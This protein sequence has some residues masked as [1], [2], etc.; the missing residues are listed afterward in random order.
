MG[1]SFRGV[2]YDALVAASDTP[3][4]LKKFATHFCTGTNDEVVLQAASLAAKD[5]RCGSL[6]GAYNLAFSTLY[7]HSGTLAAGA[8]TISLDTLFPVNTV[9]AI[10]GAYGYAS[11]TV[12][13]SGTAVTW[14][15]G[16]VFN[17]G[18]LSGATIRINGTAYLISSVADTTHLTL[19]SSAGTQSAV[20][21]DFLA[22]TLEYRT[23]TNVSGAGP[24]VHTLNTRL[25]LAH[26]SG[27]LITVAGVTVWSNTEYE[28]MGG[29]VINLQNPSYNCSVF[30]NA[31]LL[32]TGD[33]NIKIHGAGSLNG[34]REITT[35]GYQFAVNLQHVSKS[36]VD[37]NIDNFR[38]SEAR[39]YKSTCT[40][41]NRRFYDMDRK[42]EIL[43]DMTDGT[44]DAAKNQLYHYVPVGS[45]DHQ[46]CY[47]T[48]YE[49]AATA[50][51]PNV[52]WSDTYDAQVVAD[53]TI[54]R[55]FGT[56]ALKI[57]LKKNAAGILQLYNNVWSNPVNKGGLGGVIRDMRYRIFSFWLK[58]DGVLSDEQIQKMT[59]MID[60]RL[61]APSPYWIA[62]S[63]YIS[64]A[65][66]SNMWVR[67]FFSFYNIT[68]L[69]MCM[70]NIYRTVFV[71]N[72]TNW[73][74]SI[75]A[76]TVTFY[77]GPVTAVPI[78]EGV[79]G[80]A[81]F[82]LDDLSSS[83]GTLVEP[84]LNMYG[85]HGVY[86]C[87]QDKGFADGETYTGSIP[88]LQSLRANGA[89]ICSHSY[90]HFITKETVWDELIKSKEQIQKDIGGPCDVLNIPGGVSVYTGDVIAK[91]FEVFRL[92]R[93]TLPQI[94]SSGEIVPLLSTVPIGSIG[95]T[96]GSEAVM[97]NRLL[98]ALSNHETVALYFH[99]IGGNAP[100]S[101]T[102]RLNDICTLFADL[103]IPVVTAS[104][105]IP[106]GIYSNKPD[107][108]AAKRAHLKGKQT[109]LYRTGPCAAASDTSVHAAIT[110]TTASQTITTGI[111]S[112]DVYRCLTVKGN[113]GTPTT[114]VTNVV[115]P[116]LYLPNT[117]NGKLYY[118]LTNSST[119]RTLNI[120]N[121]AA[122]TQLI[123]SG[124]R[125]GDGV[126][127]LAVQTGYNIS[128]WATITYTGDETGVLPCVVI[129][130]TNWAG[131]YQRDIIVMNGTNSTKGNRP[132]VTVTTIMAPAYANSGD[133]VSIGVCD[134]LGLSDTVET[135]TDLLYQARKASAATSFALEALGTTD[136]NIHGN[137]YQGISNM[138]V[139]V[140]TITANDAFEFTYYAL[141]S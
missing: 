41:R 25:S 129:E 132:F 76:D 93:L 92:V 29:A 79:G 94:A 40:V 19:Q 48:T 68:D 43:W 126:L 75:T 53:T 99:R 141:G 57:S 10:G 105:A 37:T 96:A 108:I 102:G 54:S 16:N 36:S 104:Q 122:R 138:T 42:E 35:G 14:V 59:S 77:L 12:N 27:C 63:N 103:G 139:D 21:Y 100:D 18:W 61:D 114:Q 84:T 130:G 2:A 124:S 38:T 64:E 72:T 58:F 17:V 90:H 95:S 78:P 86:G 22:S 80:K 49:I 98:F 62:G 44:Q 131:E 31:N 107:Y 125:S 8:T 5:G 32:G 88:M 7:T 20:A 87:N 60:F 140:G 66:H 69:K 4:K 28:I 1:T 89:E 137:G 52:N 34:H 119:T 109:R 112:P 70:S 15:S 55:P 82:S 128:G 134:K 47:S 33:T 118:S 136:F 127:Y 123:A 50:G 24:Y 83:W 111:T 120:Y 74:S 91:C 85:F 101:D 115:F 39:L 133:T 45:W 67:V 56:P 23:V 51:Y 13:T 97:F 71:F 11:G 121:D 65:L 106:L 26:L 116:S 9:L 73:D 6:P 81:F 113:Q 135:T 110:L 30:T 3:A 117:D 46:K